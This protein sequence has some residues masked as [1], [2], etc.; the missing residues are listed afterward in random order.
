M[1]KKGCIRHGVHSTEQ[2]VHDV[3]LPRPL[4]IIFK[5]SLEY[6]KTLP[7]PLIIMFQKNF[8]EI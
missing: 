5:I 6:L 4:I 1:T 2:V 7:K 8:I 3:A